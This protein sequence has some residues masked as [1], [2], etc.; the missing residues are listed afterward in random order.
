MPEI[1]GKSKN[2]SATYLF[3]YGTLRKGYPHINAQL[4]EKSAFYVGH[5]YTYGKIYEINN[6]P[7]LI[8]LPQC[9][10]KVYGDVY[11]ISDDC[12]NIINLTDEYEG[13][14]NPPAPNDLYKRVCSQVCIDTYWIEAFTY[15]FSGETR[16][17]K[18][19]DSGDYLAY[20]GLI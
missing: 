9:K 6:Y 15:I 11:D 7:G 8:L 18:W 20:S 12:N 10:D 3:V 19:I 17:L 14:S 13:V 4:L 16:G 5:G 1:K 2:M